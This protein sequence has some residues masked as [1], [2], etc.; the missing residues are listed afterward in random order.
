[1]PLRRLRETVDVCK[2]AVVQ[3]GIPT[4]GGHASYTR[5]NPTCCGAAMPSPLAV[6]N[7]LLQ[8]LGA[9]KRNALFTSAGGVLC[10][11]TLR[12]N[13]KRLTKYEETK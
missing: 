1:M 2:A 12:T 13:D 3:D 6:F 7:N 10:Q 9:S 5:G 8:S 4:C 11:G